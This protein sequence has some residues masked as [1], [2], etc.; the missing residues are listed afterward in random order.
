RA[1]GTAD[2]ARAAR[3]GRLMAEISESYVDSGHGARL[4]CLSAGDGP[5]T[6]V[7]IPGWTMTADVFEHQ[8]ALAD[9][10]LRVVSFDPRGQGDS[11]KDWGHH[12]YDTRAD[13]VARVVDA[14][15][16]GPVVVGSWSQGTFE[17]LSF[18]R[19]H[20][21]ERTAGALIID[22]APRQVADD[23]DREWA[24]FE[25]R[26]DAPWG[27]SRAAWVAN[28]AT[29]RLAFHTRFIGWMRADPPTEVG[30]WF[31]AMSRRPPDGIASLINA[32]A[33]PM[34]FQEELRV[35]S[36]SQ[37][38]LVVARQDWREIVHPWVQDNAPDA[39]FE[40]M[41]EHASF[42][43]SPDG[44]NEMLRGFLTESL[45]WGG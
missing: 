14:F 32:M 38:T 20:G 41:P 40:T 21:H 27:I 33:I 8:L 3:A 13:D 39:R 42:W 4:R 28:P 1:R 44:F 15:A 30:E 7:L 24:W 12:D 16:S 11:T 36:R 34:A 26:P 10:G 37:P 17:H 29:A 45:G 43:E 35:L 23:T 5:A 31:A 25:T 22:G 19:R 6:L 2:R 18:I 9:E